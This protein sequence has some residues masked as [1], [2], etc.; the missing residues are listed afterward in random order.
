MQTYVLVGA[1]VF[2]VAAFIG[3]LAMGRRAGK[4][5]AKVDHAEAGVV[6]AARMQEAREQ[7][8]STKQD[9]LDEL[10]NGGKL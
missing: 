2:I 4:D 9:V 5:A 8:P 3:V 6:V 1:L 7:A 10:R